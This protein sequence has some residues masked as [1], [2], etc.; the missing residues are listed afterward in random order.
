MIDSLISTYGDIIQ[1]DVHTQSLQLYRNGVLYRQYTVSTSRYGTGEAANSYKTPRGL[2][3]IVTRF[4]KDKPLGTRFLYREAQSEIV[5]DVDQ[6]LSLTEQEAAPDYITT[7]ILWLSGLEPGI[8]SGEGCD[9]YQRYIYLHGT[10][11]V[12]NIGK[13]AS[14]GCVRMT[15]EDIADLFTAIEDID[16]IRVYIFD[17]DNVIS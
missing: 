14:A 8:N 2:H 17:S 7:R 13:P 16:S 6:L 3:E 1:V 9:S 15:N 12:G 4:G 5:A 11:Y 10:P